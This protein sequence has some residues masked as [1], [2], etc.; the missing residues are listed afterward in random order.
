MPDVDVAALVAD[1]DATDRWIDEVGPRFD[2]SF[3]GTVRLPGMA[4]VTVLGLDGLR[5]VIRGWLSQW[6]SFQVEIDDVIE[7]GAF[8]V[9]VYRATA[10]RHRD[11]PEEE[12]R[13]TALWT[14][15]DGLIVRGDFNIP[16]SEA[17]AAA[18]VADT[19][20]R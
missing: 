20:P 7:N 19:Q 15:R 6:A 4:P 14:L 3:E 8:V 9:M 12:R 5:S 1:D 10:R 17:L 11:A 13:R 2:P 16:Y 18:G